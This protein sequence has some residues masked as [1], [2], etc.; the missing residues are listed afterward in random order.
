VILNDD[1]FNFL[2]GGDDLGVEDLHAYLH[3]LRDTHVD[4]VAYVA[5]EGGWLT[6]YDSEVG[7]PL[8]TGFAITDKVRPRRFW[9]NLQ[10][11]KREA[12]DYLGEVFSTLQALGIRAVASFRMNDAHMS[13]D[14]TGYCAG[15]FWMNHPEWRLGE[16]YGY[17]GA[18]LNYSV[19]AVRQMLRRLVVEVIERYPTLDGIEL[20]GMR[21]PFFFPPG[22]GRQKA[23]IITDLL[24]EIRSD[25]DKA[26]HKRGKESYLL[27]VNVPRSPQLCLEVGLDVETWDAEQLVD[28]IAT[29]CYGTDF[30]LP[31]NEWKERL[32]H[33]LVYAYLNCGRVG[34]Q[35]HSLEEYRGA[36]ANAYAQGADGIYLFNFPCLDELAGLIPRPLNQPPFPPP[37]FP[38]T[39]WHPDLRETRKA[40]VELGDPHLLKHRDKTFLFY[41]EPPA[42]YHWPP[43]EA[44]IARALPQPARLTFRCYEDFAA[45]REV[46]LE[47]KV[48]GVSIRDKFDLRLNDA[49]LAD[50][51]VEVLYAPGGRDQRLHPT[52]LEPYFWFKV[53]AAGCL[54]SGENVLTV[55][56]AEGDP[57]LIGNIEVRE[58]QV[59][60]SY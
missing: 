32:R 20:D 46:L 50:Q 28:G 11:L 38:A 33:T 4:M 23:P 53:N 41:T 27:W 21:S 7:E 51:R 48:V 54:K 18:C 15:R 39:N 37:D 19:P 9:H 42:Y 14:P 60:V 2:V 36:A 13:S 12:G 35:Y 43:E 6:L 31:L 1:G 29:G 22:E 24:R 40:L 49:P 55:T 52:P 47:F 10:R 3:R 26:A 5:A 44:N 17:Y 34:C 16:I 57:T 30:Q 8:G 25:L 59:H 56:L 58:M 45:A